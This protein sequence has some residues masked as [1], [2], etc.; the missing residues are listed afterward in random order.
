M[1]AV[2]AVPLQL[3]ADTISTLNTDA[4][5]ALWAYG[6]RFLMRY[7]EETSAEEI[8]SLLGYGF[9]LG[10]C[11]LAEDFNGQ[12]AVGKLQALGVPPGVDIF[13]DVEGVEL[14]PAELI[15]KIAAWSAPVRMAGY[16]PAMY[17][18]AGALLTSSELSMLPVYR[19]WRGCSRLVDRFGA[20]VEP[21]RGFCIIQGRPDDTRIGGTTVDVDFMQTDYLGDLPTMVF[22]D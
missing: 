1:R 2:R 10:F 18:G 17:V 7:I 15:A 21:T 6:C 20:V 4:A 14:D 19:Y 8:A 12:A 13:L 16:G 22:A 9:A 3:G 5:R 11:T